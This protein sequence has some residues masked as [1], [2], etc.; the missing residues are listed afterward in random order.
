MSKLTTISKPAKRKR[1]PVR[2]DKQAGIQTFDIDNIYPQRM[3]AILKASGLALSCVETLAE[4]L[5]GKGFADQAVNEAVVNEQTGETGRDILRKAARSLAQNRGFAIHCDYDLNGDVTRIKSLPW[6][7]VR[8]GLP[9]PAGNIQDLKYSQNWEQDSDK[10]KRVIIEYPIFKEDPEQVLHQINSYGGIFKYPGQIFYY[11]PEPGTYPLVTFDPVVDSVQ[12]DAEIQIF[13]LANIQNGFM[14][15]TV[16]H[17]PGRISEVE[18]G[19]QAIQ[20]KLEGWKGSGN[21]NSIFVIEDPDGVVDNLVE[22][23]QLPNND[24]LFESTIKNVVNR[25][26][27]RYGTPKPL[28]AVSPDSGL[29]NEEDMVNSYK[30]YNIKTQKQR[31]LLTDQ[32]G[33]IFR[34]MATPLSAADNY[35]IEPAE[36]TDQGAETDPAPAAPAPAQPTPQPLTA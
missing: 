27:Q 7:F 14:A 31:K 5:E 18:G 32:L 17:W 13:E 15:G 25:I 1:L 6:E 20:Q 36:F 16:I 23:L 8:M 28:L 19:E 26:I 9:D 29:F 34:R 22:S 21:A 24:K 3:D 12:T 35:T 4:F 33:R 2:I 30:Y 10:P 11:T